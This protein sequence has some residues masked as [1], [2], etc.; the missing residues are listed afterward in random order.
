MSV[1]P[2]QPIIGIDG[3]FSFR[4]A[5]L[6]VIKMIQFSSLLSHFVFICFYVLLLLGILSASEN[7]KNQKGE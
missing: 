1:I 5:L 4:L 3:S 6:E 7:M 2:I